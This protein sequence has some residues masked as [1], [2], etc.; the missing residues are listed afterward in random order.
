MDSGTIATYI[1]AGVILAGAAIFTGYKARYATH[2]IKV[3]KDI[4]FFL[5]IVVEF[6][7]LMIGSSVLDGGMTGM[8]ILFMGVFDFFYVEGHHIAV[9][10]DTVDLDL[11]EWGLQKK[12]VGPVAHFYNKYGEHC[13]MLPTLKCSAKALLGV[14]DLLEMDMSKIRR[15]RQ[16]DVWTG[17]RYKHYDAITSIRLP[18]TE[19]SPVGKIKI[20]SR[21]IVLDDDSIRT[22]PRYLFTFGRNQHTIIFSDSA[23]S[24]PNEFELR[25]A[26]YE[27]AI[28]DAQIARQEVTRLNIQMTAAKYDAASDII[29]GLLDLNIDVGNAREILIDRISTEI[30]ERKQKGVQNAENP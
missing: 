6:F 17:R 15:S 25:T 14:T 1:M 8:M 21:K 13:I 7:A 24:D 11:F 28:L 9:P 2:Q 23:L 18:P 10:N 16:T 4:T 22:I 3:R 29:K 26:L 20:G 19:L 27:D 12:T 5:L 30:K